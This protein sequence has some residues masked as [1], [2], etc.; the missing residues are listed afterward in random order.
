VGFGWF[1]PGGSIAP[2]RIEHWKRHHMTQGHI[3]TDRATKLWDLINAVL[4]RNTRW[5]G[6][7]ESKLR[8]IDLA[9]IM[10]VEKVLRCCLRRLSNWC[11]NW[12]AYPS[13][14][15]DSLK[16][17]CTHCSTSCDPCLV[18]AQPV[19]QHNASALGGRAERAHW[20]LV[21]WDEWVGE[22]LVPE[23]LLRVMFP[24]H[25][26]YWGCYQCTVLER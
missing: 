2:H 23:V 14:L 26:C 7:G 11:G 6:G 16:Y 13:R 20:H 5:R 10:P 25:C 21:G 15:L 4:Y 24:G 8:G 3:Q 18:L 22:Q 1:L 9:V 17:C 19:C 12:E